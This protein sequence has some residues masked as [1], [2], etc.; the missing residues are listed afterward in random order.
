MPRS[1]VV[2]RWILLAIFL[3]S[4]TVA[5]FVRST[6]YSGV[7]A[8]DGKYYLTYKSMKFET[9]RERYEDAKWRN[10]LVL[11]ATTIMMLSLFAFI[12]L[13]PSHLRVMPQGTRTSRMRFL[14]LRRK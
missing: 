3:G 9:S 12:L 1:I 5:V 4:V 11:T 7:F 8:K 2:I 13:T 10:P 6:G 14:R